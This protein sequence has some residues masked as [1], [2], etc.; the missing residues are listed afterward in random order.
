[1]FGEMLDPFREHTLR[2]ALESLHGEVERASESLR[3]LLSGGAKGC[4]ELLR[5]GFRVACS[6]TR[7]RTSQLLDLPMLDVADLAAD[8]LRRLLQL[9]FDLLLQLVLASPQPIRNLLQRTPAVRRVLLELG[10][11]V[12]RDVLRGTVDL[13][14]ETAD[15]RTV[16]LDRDL[17]PLG[18]VVDLRLCIGG[19][20]RDALRDARELCG[21]ALLQLSEV[22]DPDRQP[23]V[24]AALGFGESLQERRGCVAAARGAR[25]A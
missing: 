10:V 1:M 24:D 21:K 5:C 25:A 20:L 2:V 23:L 6:L 15:Q 7:D 17:Q 18:L 16:R 13:L 11:R 3:G 12:P 19:D 14:A 8:P 22:G 4:L 9:A